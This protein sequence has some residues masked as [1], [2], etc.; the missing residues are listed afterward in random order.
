MAAWMSERGLGD[1]P[2]EDVSAVTGGTQNLMLRFN[3]SGRPYVLRRG[4][5][6]LRPRSNAVI[7]RETR[8]LAA[9]AGSDVPHPRLIA[10]CDDP[11]VLG[12]A[13]FYLME[14]V[15]GFNAGEGLPPLHAGNAAVRFGMG[16]SMA[17]ALARLGAVDHVG[18]GLAD[19]GKPDGFLER[20]VPR[21]L[22]ELESYQQYDGYPGPQIPGIEQVS[23]WL[24]RHRPTAWTP[25]IM[26]GDYHAANVMFSWTGP[27][28]V[29][30]VDWEMSTIGDPLLDLGW[31]LATWRQPDGSSVFSHALGG[32]RGLASTDDLLHRYAANS[33]RD[34][35]HITWYTVLAC[36]KLGIVIE[37]TLARACAGKAEKEV[38]D[39]LH[40]ATVHLFERALTIIES[41]H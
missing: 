32:Q 29:A 20:Q 18:V 7:L 27:A 4:P 9:L 21:W 39:Q 2:L 5:R 12:D 33:T 11:G 36:F 38:G 3:R 34:L 15:E 6:H 25:G 16:L 23:G 17:D 10:T 26:H 40:A 31:L 30:I 13:V 19:F 22:S 37:G 14:P 35:S 24:Q 1:G 28:V 8:V 41:P